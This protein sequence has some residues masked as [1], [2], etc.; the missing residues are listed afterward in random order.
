MAQERRKRGARRRVK[1]GL[2]G[3]TN[4]YPFLLALGMRQLGH[5]VVLLVNRQE[6]LH[7]PEAKFP[8]LASGY[9]PWIVDC[10]DV[11]LDDWVAASPRIQ[12]AIN[13]LA[14]GC[15]AVLLNDVGPSLVPYLD[16]PTM[17]VS[18]GSD[19]TYLADFATLETIQQG[20]SDEYRRSPGG[21]FFVRRW[22]EFIERQRAGV[23]SACA[24]AASL[25]GLVP[26]TDAVLRDLGVADSRR[27]FLYLAD[28]LTPV[29]RQRRS[30]P[31]LRIVNGARL[32]W[33]RPLP[34]GCSSQDHKGT[35]VLLDGFAEFIRSGGNAVLVMFRKGLDVGA[36]EDRVRDL[37]LERHV[38]WRDEMSVRDFQRELAQADI[39]CDQ[40]GESFPGM[41]ALD[42]MAIG[43]PV[44]ANFRMDLLGS[45]FPSPM[46][47]CH[48]TA[49][50]DVAEH[51]GRLADSEA[52]RVRTGLAG[53]R[54]AR[55]HLSP[56]ANA[57]RC[58]ARLG[59]D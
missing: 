20:W 49:A 33:H 3:N 24:V 21:T 30:E 27:E 53:R 58:L 11:A 29:Q 25:P 44:I 6:L 47:A 46:P 5:E 14:S 31:P 51:L 32:N 41:V 10:S 56:A 1:I 57:A 4:N 2:F 55:T 40:L 37:H 7:R 50:A 15:D 43:V 19:L 45:H 18:T 17:V 34:P 9:P 52:T 59:I 48:A 8:E 26:A 12:S 54:F 22:R 42:A 36:T 13:A 38:E 23:R 16:V 39:V 35:D 28:T